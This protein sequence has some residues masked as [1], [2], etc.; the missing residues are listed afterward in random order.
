[1]LLEI[2]YQ[3]FD[4]IRYHLLRLMAK[5]A[6]DFKNTMDINKKNII[7][8][9]INEVNELIVELQAIKRDELLK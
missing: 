7:K 5:D 9:C 2:D 6:I 3:K 4:D 1:M 8:L